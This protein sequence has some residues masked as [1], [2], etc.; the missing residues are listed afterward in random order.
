MI[1]YSKKIRSSILG[2]II[3]DVIGVPVEFI[4][5]L[6]LKTNPLTDMVGYGTHNMPAGTWSDDS[7]MIFL[8][9]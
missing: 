9:Y 4:P 2:F 3:G 6:D 1:E 7:S 8:H 5:R